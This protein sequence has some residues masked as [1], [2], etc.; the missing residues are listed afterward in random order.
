[1]GNTNTVQ[2]TLKL[3][4]EVMHNVEGVLSAFSKLLGIKEPSNFEVIDEAGQKERRGKWAQS[5]S[6]VAGM[7][8]I[9]TYQ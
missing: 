7:I 5:T 3:M 9:Y 6:P 4:P 2:V 8:K 1:M